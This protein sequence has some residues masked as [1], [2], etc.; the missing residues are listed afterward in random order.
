MSLGSQSYVSDGWLVSRNENGLCFRN[1]VGGPK[2]GGVLGRSN[3]H[4][5][6]CFSSSSF[7]FFLSVHSIVS[8]V[9]RGSGEV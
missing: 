6:L 7:W 9:S 3:Y 4:T 5:L 2:G 8:F 1:A